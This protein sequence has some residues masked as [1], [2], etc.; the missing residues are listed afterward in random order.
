MV[1]FAYNN[2]YQTSIQ[3]APYEALYGRV[4]RSQIYWT[5]VGENSIIGPGLIRDISEKVSLIHQHLLMAQSLQ[6]SYT[7]KRCRPLEFE[8]GYHIFLKVMPKREMVRFSK[9]GKLSS[10]FIRPFEILE[11]V[12][13]VAY[14]LALPPSML[15][16]HEV[17]HI[18]MRRKYTPDPTHVVDSGEITVDTDR[19]F[20]EG[21][22]RIIDRRDQVL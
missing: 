7:N 17:F 22:V 16:F 6:K 19:A 20:T 5:E 15:G 14:C 3:M 12:G 10:R 2:S 18:S 1:E 11:R 9:R 8:F 13:I 4:C 21:P